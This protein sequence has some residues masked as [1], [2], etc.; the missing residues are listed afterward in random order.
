MMEK[1]PINKQQ[2]AYK[3]LRSRILDGTYSPGYRI[4]INQ[5][6]KELS[7]STIPVRE[8]IRQLEAD[9]L[10]QYKP[11]SGAV[12]TPIDKDQY[13]ETLSTLAVLEGYATA[14]SSRVFPKTKI[15]ELQEINTQMEKALED[16]DFIRFGRLNRQFHDLICSYCNNQYLLESIRNTHNRLDSIRRMG[17]TFISYR[18]KQSIEEHGELIRMLQKDCPFA[19]IESFAREHK[20]NTVKFFQQQAEKNGSAIFFEA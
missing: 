5:I 16:F 15:S 8:A 11:Y 14:L 4:V 1:T 17:A 7:L 10:I 3:I 20:M 12:V 6:A 18:V 19:E 9:G 2:Y 13:L